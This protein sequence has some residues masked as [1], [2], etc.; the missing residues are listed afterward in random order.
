MTPYSLPYGHGT[1]DVYVRGAPADVFRSPLVP[2]LPDEPGAFRSAVRQPIRSAPLR[3]KIG[4]AERVAVV[5]PDVTR[6]F[7]ARRVLPLLLEELSHV[8]AKR[9]TIVVG[10]GTHR[11]NTP[12]E[13]AVMVGPDLL[14]TV[15]VVNHDAYDPATLA[16]AGTAPDGRTVLMNRAYVEAD[17]RILLGFLEPHFF[18]GY[19]GG[20]KA[21]FP[22]VADIDSILHYHR[23]SVIGDPRSTWGV[24]DGNPTQEQI[25]ACGSVLPVDFCVNVTMNSLGEI[26][27]FFGG[28]VL[29]VHR[30]GCAFVRSTNMLPCPRRYPVVVTTNGGYPLD[31]NLYQCVKGMTAA[32][33]IVTEGGLIFLAA[34]CADGF[35]AHG[36][37]TRLLFGSAS[38]SEL[39][40]RIS[41]PGFCEHDQWQAQKLAI[42]LAGARIA[43]FSG[44]PAEEVRKAHLLP[45]GDPTAFLQEEVSRAGPDARVAVM[46]EGPYAV[47]YLEEDG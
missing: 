46:P 39:L 25:R 40:S 28:D 32:A 12:A 26:T 38:A 18:S 11:A 36:N 1:L 42:L 13:L 23:A 35:P 19:S 4:A 10:T 21:V 8:P 31:Q 27:R 3:E 2:G 45:V 43:L 34:R 5:I 29:A 20:Y 17:R 44:L 6:P 22:G 41:A 33:Q 15:S 37:F 14:R 7:P 9:V 16:P 30:E 47:P 24:L